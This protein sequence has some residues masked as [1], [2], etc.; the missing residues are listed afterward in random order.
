LLRDFEGTVVMGHV[1]LDDRAAI[2]PGLTRCSRPGTTVVTRGDRLPTI[3][4][5]AGRGG[6][7]R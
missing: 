4:D 3:S 5:E 6:R 2:L 7:P 1:A